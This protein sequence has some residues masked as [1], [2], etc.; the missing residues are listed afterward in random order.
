MWKR[1]GMGPV[2]AYEILAECSPL[3]GLRG[4][5]ALRS[6][7]ADRDDHRLDHEGCTLA[8]LRPPLQAANLQADGEA[9]RVVF[10]CDGG[11]PGIAGVA[12]GAGS[13]GGINLHRSSARD[14]LARDGDRPLGHGD[15]AGKARRAAGT[16][17]RAHCVRRAGRL[18]VGLT[19]RNRVWSD[20]RLVRRVAFAWLCWSVRW[21]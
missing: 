19:R 14:T 21:R 18:P 13:R 1:W 2:F 8:C 20:R 17:R 4:S 6:G 15:R 3:A 10:L 12:G 7:D 16:S 5:L 11:H 9:R